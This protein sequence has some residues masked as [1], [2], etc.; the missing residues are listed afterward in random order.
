MVRRGGDRVRADGDHAGRGDLGADLLAG[1][2]AADAGLGALA[3]LDLDGGAR[4]QVLRGDAEAPR[5]DLN[6]GAV[7]VGVQVAVQ[8][9]LTGVEVGAGG[10]GDNLGG[11]FPPAGNGSDG[12]IRFTYS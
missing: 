3:D 11:T 10:L 1:E 9:A 12:L 7:G 2:M 8:A 5:G 4:L 6:D